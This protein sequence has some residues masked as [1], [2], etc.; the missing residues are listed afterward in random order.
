MSDR[1]DSPPEVLVEAGSARRREASA[2]LLS[3]A[4]M[5]PA[6]IPYVCHYLGRPEGGTTTGFICYDM[7]YYFANGR[8]HFDNG[9]FQP[10]YG[11]PSD[12]SY[13]SPQIYFQPMSFVL[14]LV[15]KATKVD[16]GMLWM[17]FGFV[18]ALCCA[19]VALALYRHLVGLDSTARW[20]GLVVFFWGGGLLALSGIAHALWTRPDG[21]FLTGSRFLVNPIYVFQF[22]PFEGWWFL[23]FGRNLVFP[24][25]ALYHAIFLGAILC[26]L[27]EKYLWTIVL[28]FV[29]SISHPF[30]GIELLG[31]L[32]TWS[33]VEVFFVGNK[34]MPKYFPLACFG[35][36]AFHLGYYLV[37]LNKFDAH[38]SLSKQWTL[39]WGVDA[40]Q[41][42]PAYALVGAFALWGFRRLPLAREFFSESKNRLFLIWFAV[43]FA[44]A[45]HEFAV[46]PPVQ[47]IHFTRGYDWLP[48]F[49]LGVPSIIGLLTNLLRRPARPLRLAAVGVVMSLFLVDNAL[50]FA[51]FP[52]K[53]ANHQFTFDVYITPDQREVMKTLNRLGKTRG[54][55]VAQDHLISYLSS[56]YT[57]LRSWMG[58]LANTPD[59]KVRQ[60]ELDGFFA[61]GKFQEPWESQT[62]LVVLSNQT[63]SLAIQKPWLEARNGKKVMENSSFS[64]YRVG[65]TQLTAKAGE[66]PIKR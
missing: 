4:L 58:H 20:L 49:F 29:M 19:R 23:N 54:V 30:T 25:E 5:L 18:A 16:P 48:L 55:V 40:Y 24:N 26:V 14:G 51:Y 56:V 17:G 28:A 62:L 10:T 47:P 66:P 11:N 12:Y 8:E 27:R 9:T 63:A 65:P 2:W 38:R 57:P 61:G 15:W 1:V 3:L 52:I 50:W 7:A 31:I 41:F 37:F 64:V 36:S 35:L 59:Q 22:D 60:A 39:D 42:V 33:A 45:N 44:M 46:R 13:E 6:V 53:V 21:L 32:G 43:V 34:R